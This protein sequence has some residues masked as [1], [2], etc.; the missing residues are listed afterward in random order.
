MKKQERH[1]R[2]EPAMEPR[3]T[4]TQKSINIHTYRGKNTADVLT[5]IVAEQKRDGRSWAASAQR[6]TEQVS[7][8]MFLLYFSFRTRF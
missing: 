2:Q 7:Y 5:R 1:A 3:C 8:W 6:H 4:L